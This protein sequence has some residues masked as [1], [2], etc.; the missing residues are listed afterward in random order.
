MSMLPDKNTVPGMTQAA[1]IP[2]TFS[3]L[4]WHHCLVKKEGTEELEKLQK[5]LN[6][7]H[8]YLAMD[9]YSVN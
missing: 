3:Y 8:T 7:L 5:K 4:T 6:R 2:F 1:F 9:F